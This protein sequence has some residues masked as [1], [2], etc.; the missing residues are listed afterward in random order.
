MFAFSEKLQTYCSHVLLLLKDFKYTCT[1]NK[2]KKTV[3]ESDRILTLND[4]EV[5]KYIDWKLLS[6][7]SGGNKT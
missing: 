3:P 2:C 7:R 1:N 5:Q 4:S 6:L